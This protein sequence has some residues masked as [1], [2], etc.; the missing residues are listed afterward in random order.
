M[1]ENIWTFLGQD[2]GE[3]AGRKAIVVRALYGL[4]SARADFRNSL[5]ECMHHLGFLICHANLDL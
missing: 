1:T 2:F 5:E 4:K 3:D